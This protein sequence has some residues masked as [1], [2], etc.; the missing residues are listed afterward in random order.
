[1]L[2]LLLNS[3]RADK[4]SR[5]IEEH[6]TGMQAPAL[7]DLEVAQVLRRWCTTNSTTSRITNSITDVSVWN[8]L[9]LLRLSPID[10]YPHDALLPRVWSLRSN[11]TAY[12]AVYVALAETLKV[13]LIT[14]DARM[15][16]APVKSVRVT[17]IK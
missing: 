4:V 15:S 10:R 8:M 1:M 14:C 11:L 3:A 16:R 17:V 2:E 7:L 5:Q 13:R 6:G 9:E 12:D